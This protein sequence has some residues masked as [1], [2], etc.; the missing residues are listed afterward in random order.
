MNDPTKS[1]VPFMHRLVEEDGVT[2]V[3]QADVLPEGEEWWAGMTFAE[4]RDEKEAAR[5]A[6]AKLW[7]LAAEFDEIAEGGAK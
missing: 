6:A 4:D 3:Y 2:P 7:K 1:C 5:R